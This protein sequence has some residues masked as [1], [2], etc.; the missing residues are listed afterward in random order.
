MTTNETYRVGDKAN[1]YVL[2]A[3]GWV[4]DT[5][6]VKKG[7][8]KGKKIVLGVVA[9][10]LLLGIGGALAGGGSSTPASAPAPVVA[11]A[12]ATPSA[13]PSTEAPSAAPS[14]A[15]VSHADVLTLAVTKVWND[16]TK[17]DKANM[18]IAF[19]NDPEGA[20]NAWMDGAVKGG[21]SHVD[22]YDSWTVLVGIMAKQ[23]PNILTGSA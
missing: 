16:S 7:M 8:S 13:A 4:A 5:A 9:G 11:S 19:L 10:F 20:M 23:C 22:A 17:A 2:T 3:D 14:K 21:T 15:E 6:P 12:P 1:G 18:C